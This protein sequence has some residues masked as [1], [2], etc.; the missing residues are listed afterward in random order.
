MIKSN[1]KILDEFGK[2][3]IKDVYDD[4]VSYFIN[5]LTGETKWGTGKEYTRV[6]DNLNMDD[7]EILLKY[8]KSS[9]G[10]IIFAML[11]IFEENQEFKIIH[12]SEGH[13]VNLNEIS[14]MLKAEP[15][16]E[17]GWIDRF[18]QYSDKKGE[19]V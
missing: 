5:L 3:I 8:I 16:I 4:G 7:K 19:S 18:S 12:E 9:F 13:R 1:K 10:T 6:F 11:S 14:E 17:G 15:T 2:L